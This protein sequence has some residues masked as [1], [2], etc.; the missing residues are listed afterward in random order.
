MRALS[1]PIIVLVFVLT[2]CTATQLVSSSPRSVTIKARG[3]AMQEAQD[4]AD[5][6]CAKGT[7][8]ARMIAVPNPNSN[9]FR[10]DCVD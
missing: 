8:F 9:Q 4:M 6:E 5:K 2:G 7:R 3:A 10:F 1:F